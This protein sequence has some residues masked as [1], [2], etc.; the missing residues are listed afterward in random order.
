MGMTMT[1][2]ILAAHAGLESVVPGQLIEAE[3][4]IVLGNDVTSPVAIRVFEEIG[5]KEVFDS[6]KKS[7]HCTRSL[8]TKQRHSIG[9]TVP[10]M[11]RLRKREGD[12]ELFRTRRNGNRTCSAAGEGFGNGR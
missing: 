5:K 7:G 4:D 12:R 3:T 10:Q 2:K 1:Q 6:S 8:C 9:G 11:P